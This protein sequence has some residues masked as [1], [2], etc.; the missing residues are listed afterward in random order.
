[1]KKNIKTMM[2]LA[3]IAGLMGTVYAKE[4][5]SAKS[6]DSVTFADIIK[7]NSKPSLMK[8]HKNWKAEWKTPEGGVIQ[9]KAM[10]YNSC[11]L[12]M[13]SKMAY[14][15]YDLTDVRTEKKGTEELHTKNQVFYY[16]LHYDG[17]KTANYEW[18]ILPEQEIAKIDYIG[19][20]GLIYDG[21]DYGEEYKSITDNKDGTLTM[22][23]IAP[24]AKMSDV[25][26]LPDEWKDAQIE[27]NC[28]VDSNTLEQIK[29]Y[30]YIITKTE[31]I[32][33]FTETIEY[34]VKFPE[35]SKNMEK[36]LKF[37]NGQKFKNS[38]NITIITDPGTP[39]EK[40][41]KRKAD[42][43]FK[44]YPIFPD[45]YSVFADKEG[46]EPYKGSDGKR[47]VTIYAIKD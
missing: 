27:Y 31:R 23:S 7:A 1:M 43:S 12:Y 16:D 10:D 32:L 46:K 11:T 14:L 38:R 2:V 28:I 26:V 30:A 25:R 24:A 6:A 8:N 15:E 18:L 3:V 22:L 20:W 5:A 35:N 9:A 41:Y 37:I 21:S 34:D 13:N 36:M 42:V 17:S 40:I 44:V 4:K 39:S 45:G 29:L 19:N 47:D 33:Y